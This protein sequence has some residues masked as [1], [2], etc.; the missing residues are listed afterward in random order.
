MTLARMKSA[1]VLFLLVVVA[2]FATLA[3]P[4]PE[5]KPALTIN[6][7]ASCLAFSPD[8]KT[9][10]CGLVLR[11]LATGKVLAKGELDEKFPP[12]THVAFSPDGN[13]L[14][15]V[16]LVGGLS[17]TSHAVCLWD[18]SRRGEMKASTLFLR[19]IHAPGYERSVHYLAFSPDG[20]MLVTRSLD[21]GA[22]VW[23]TAS[24]KERRRLDVQ[25]LAVAFGAAGRTLISVSRDGLVRHWNLFTGKGADSADAKGRD[26]FLFVLDAVAS[27]DGKTLALTDGYTVLLK[28]ART[29][30]TL[31]RFGDLN[32]VGP[33][34]LSA[35]GKMLGIETS[36][37]IIVFDTRTGKESRWMERRARWEGPF[38]ISP[39][40]RFIAAG[41]DE[42]VTVWEMAHLRS[43]EK[44]KGRRAVMPLEATVSSRKAAYTLDLGGKTPE[45]FARTVRASTLP[46]SP[47]IDL[48]VTLRN[49]SDKNLIVDP[50]GHFDAYLIGDGAMNHPDL[51]R[52]TG[53][54]RGEEI[55][56]PEKIVLAPGGSYSLPLT[57]LSYRYGRQSYWLQPGEYT[58]YVSYCT[59]VNPAPE[60]WTKLDDGTGIGT[61]RAAPIRLKVVAEKK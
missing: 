45:E 40:A 10:A 3:G 19:D 24:G 4:P 9:L 20:R 36:D 7:G 13:R 57:T 15:S 35:D 53:V 61:L 30:K 5:K 43:R 50:D 47:K 56:E 28:D 14:A 51:P 1:A 23:E 52:Q 22:V 29:G 8:G 38:A 34:A 18:I 59:G 26:G 37:G 48:V 32:P 60:G 21:G 17:E 58:L 44:G 2:P 42:S 54:V 12:C 27:A 39:D 49:T 25:G 41:L 31:R 11:E 55:I 16:H 33:M 46:P 6:E